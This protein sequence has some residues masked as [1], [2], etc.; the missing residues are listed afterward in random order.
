MNVATIPIPERMRH[1]PVDRRGYPVPVIVMIKDGRPEFSINDM[2][3]TN[4]MI[5]EDR[6][7]ICGGK[8]FRGRWLVGGGLSALSGNGKFADAPAHNEC[9]H[10]ALQVCPYLATPNWRT[11]IGKARA[12]QNNMVAFGLSDSVDLA[13]A[14]R[15][16]CFVAVM[17]SKIDIEQR[18]FGVTLCRPRPG[19]VMRVE[20]WRHGRQLAGDELTAFRADAR[21]RVES[22]GE[23]V[24]PDVW[25]LMEPE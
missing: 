7:T 20:V 23:T 6:C 25:R 18:P 16:E 17:A 4:Q 21:R 11:T 24:R 1:L 19:H 14:T 5:V 13:D 3:V 2:D 10:Y 22:I 8:L 15:P 9:T 12:A